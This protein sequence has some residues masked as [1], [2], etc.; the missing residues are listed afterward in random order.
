VHSVGDENSGAM[1]YELEDPEG[2]PLARVKPQAGGQ[3]K[4]SEE[5]FSRGRISSRPH[6]KKFNFNFKTNF[7]K[8]S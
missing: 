3:T 4:F 2:E 8:L 1:F 6:I 7:E 5:N